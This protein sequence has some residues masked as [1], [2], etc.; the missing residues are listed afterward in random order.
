MLQ[1]KGTVSHCLWWVKVIWINRS[2]FREKPLFWFVTFC[3]ASPIY[4]LNKLRPRP[5][6]NVVETYV[7]VGDCDDILPQAIYYR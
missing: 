6:E 5:C 7:T 3:N 4:N 1:L 2:D